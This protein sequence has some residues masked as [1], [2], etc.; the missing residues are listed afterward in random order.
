MDSLNS[1]LLENFVLS[2]S[3]LF[4][5]FLILLIW[6]LI[7]E[8]RTSRKKG[9][10]PEELSEEVRK[11]LAQQE[12]DL[13]LLD[14]DIQ[15]LYN[16]SNRINALSMKGIHKVGLVRFNPFKD[17]G[18]DQSFSLALLNGKNSGFVISSFYGREGARIYCKSVIEGQADKHPFNKEEEEAI[19]LAIKPKKI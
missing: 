10:L 3:A 6:I 15:E 2:F 5:G 7:L 19:K 11:I 9:L 1:F 18:G 13:R 12:K 16:I 8:L 17:I 4:L 14:K